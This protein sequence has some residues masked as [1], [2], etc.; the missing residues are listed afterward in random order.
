[1]QTGHQAVAG[2][3]TH[4]MMSAKRAIAFARASSE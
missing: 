3:V 4:A 2:V 1:M